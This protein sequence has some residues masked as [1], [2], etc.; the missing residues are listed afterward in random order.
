MSQVMGSGV[1]NTLAATAGDIAQWGLSSSVPTTPDPFSAVS[2]N[3]SGVV[4]VH[5]P[6]PSRGLSPSMDAAPVEHS[7]PQDFL[8]LAEGI[9]IMPRLS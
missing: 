8:T 6:S 5:D 2:R 1:F 4:D 3:G 7:R 9:G